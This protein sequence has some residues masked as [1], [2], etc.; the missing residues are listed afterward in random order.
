MVNLPEKVYTFIEA[1]DRSPNGDGGLVQLTSGGIG[2]SYFDLAVR[3]VAPGV[4]VNVTFVAYSV[5]ELNG[6][7]NFR[8]GTWKPGM[9]TLA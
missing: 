2:K 4:A 8:L 1:F 7:Q 9:E 6:G 5:D 3:S